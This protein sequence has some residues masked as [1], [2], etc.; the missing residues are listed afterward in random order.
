MEHIEGG[1]RDAPSLDGTSGTFPSRPLLHL[2]T[3]PP[4]LGLQHGLGLLESTG[5]PPGCY[6]LNV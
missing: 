6:G 2:L 5:G 3:R 1:A 4:S